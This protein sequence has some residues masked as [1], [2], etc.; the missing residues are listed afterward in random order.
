ML[1]SLI[2][3]VLFVVIVA[4][5]AWGAGYLSE[6]DEGG[7][8]LT[9]AGYEYNLGPLETAIA[10]VLLLVAAW[11]L[12][13]VVGLL[14]ATLRFINGDDTAIS[15]YFSQRSER[16][17]FDALADGMMALAAGDGRE[18]L[19]K[20]SRA[21]RYLH[22]P[23]LTGLLTAQ[24]AEMVGDRQRA[25]RT[26][27]ELLADERTRFVGIRGI[28]KQKLAEGDT[29]TALKLAQKA[30]AIRPKHEETQDTLL[31]LQTR[32]GMWG[33]ARQTLN[34]KLKSGNMPRDLHKRRD[35]VLALAEAKGVF[36]EAG[37]IE[38]R[39]AAIE[40]NRLSPDLI[41]A[42]VLAAKAYAEQGKP[43]YAARV[44]QKAWEA[45]PHPDLAAA[46]AAIH[47]GES[48][49][50][51]RKRFRPLVDRHPDHTETK[52]LKAELA[53][54]AEDFPAARRALGDLAT[55]HP[56]AR[57]MAIMAA[58]ERGEG[59]DD[60]VVRAWLARALTAPRGPQW[61]CDN[62]HNI[63]GAWVPVCENCGAFDSLSWTDPPA[64]EAQLPGGADMLPLLVGPARGLDREAQPDTTL[65]ATR[66]VGEIVDP[67][68]PEDTADG[69][70]MP[71]AETPADVAEK[72]DR[73]TH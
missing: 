73:Q 12:F 7:L 72:V 47:E 27:K 45:R 53:I 37:T 39:E 9:W 43:K 67:P 25:E 68:L 32:E 63:H 54:A 50:A 62:C 30:F 55:S 69:V 48:P 26:Y 66:P 57:V 11:V 60:N 64:A 38:T 44:I 6:L 58:V 28:M 36:D 23:E 14:V 40:A 52:L 10:L 65:P 16:K 17:G 49:E 3:I 21:D 4:A 51:R 8:R 2:K 33:D 22:R 61:V 1:W 34:A 46:F 70:I 29:D 35:A 41:P 20:A 71:A 19:S 18:A 59:A 5:I 42:A 15:R 13:K 31:R 24:A 56:D